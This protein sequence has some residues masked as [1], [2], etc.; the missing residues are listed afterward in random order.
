MTMPGAYVPGE[1]TEAMSLIPHV[2]SECE[3]VGRAPSMMPTWRIRSALT[4]AARI[5]RQLTAD[6]GP[7][8][9]VSFSEADAEESYGRPITEDEYRTL[10]KALPY[11]SIPD[12]FSEVVFAVC[13]QGPDEDD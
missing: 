13:S 1:Y 8:N 12:A 11:S 4:E 6:N 3:E 2:L 10:I 9:L 7:R 5:I